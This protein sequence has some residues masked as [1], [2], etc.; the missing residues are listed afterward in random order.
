MREAAPTFARAASAPAVMS[1]LGLRR[2]GRAG[3]L[4]SAGR[5]ASHRAA[6]QTACPVPLECSEGGLDASGN[7]QTSVQSCY[8]DI[9][10]PFGYPYSR[11]CRT[12]AKWGYFIDS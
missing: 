2:L 4:M 3:W 7:Y 5:D 11:I 8:T 10:E 9:Q 12:S 1:S 6:K